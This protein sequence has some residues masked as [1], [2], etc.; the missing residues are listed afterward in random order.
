MSST[1]PESVFARATEVTKH[2]RSSLPSELHRPHV[3]IVCGSG[4]GGL[5][6]TISPSPRAEFAY[7]SLPYFPVSTGE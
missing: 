5:Q 2:L 6:H 1:A 7:E 4:L 3:A